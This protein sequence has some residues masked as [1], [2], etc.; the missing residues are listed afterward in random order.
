[1]GRMIRRTKRTGNGRAYR[2]AVIAG[3][4]I[5]PEVVAE[6]VKVLKAVA[7]I[8]GFRLRF[9]HYP[10]GA[11]HYLRT[12]EL[13]PDKAFAKVR[14]SDAILLGAAGDPR[15]PLGFIER[16]IVGKLR[17]DLDLYVNLRP[18]R[19]YA[20]HLCPVKGKRAEDLDILVVRENTEDVYASAPSFLRRGTPDE[21]AM[22]S[23]IY[24]RM[25]VE[26]VIR[27]AF[28]QA[29][30]R[31]RRKLTLVDKANAIP[32]HDLWRRAFAEIARD[33]PGVATDAVLADAACMWMV[34]NP[35]SF[36]VIVTTNLFGDIL[37][38][39]GAML[40]GGLGIAAGGNLHPG[41]V[42]MFE[43]I[44]GSAPK[45]AGKGV[46]NPLA[47]IAAAGML[48]DHL[49]ERRAGARIDEAIRGLLV[50]RKIPSLGADSGLRTA[51][52]G[53]LVVR[54]LTH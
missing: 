38:D 35:E 44:H 7:R 14:A 22:Q 30:R 26:R 41:K 54:E 42:S 52:I 31:P 10:F 24:T 33:Y 28:E 48:C 53:D 8:E 20:E 16:G 47:T 12:K 25:G 34:K 11:E 36:D 45:Y 27:Y 43:P 17:F 21:V 13:F 23:M 50:T 2:I 3:D 40:Q 5:G 46:A 49:G 9:D 15:L 29:L 4:G 19:L 37:T 6:G 18:I 51:E 1:M 39:L 32:A